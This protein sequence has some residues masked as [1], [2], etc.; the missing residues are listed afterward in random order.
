[1]IPEARIPRETFPNLS[2]EDFYNALIAIQNTRL[3]NAREAKD[4]HKMLKTLRT[5]YVE[6]RRAIIGESNY[7]AYETVRLKHAE[8]L[9]SVRSKRMATS[10]GSEEYEKT[11]NKLGQELGEFF[12][13]RGINEEKF[14]AL[15]QEQPEKLESA[16][17]KTLGKGKPSLPMEHDAGKGISD[18]EFFPPLIGF[19]ECEPY[20]RVHEWHTDRL[21]IMGAAMFC[22]LFDC[23]EHDSEPAMYRQS[24]VFGEIAERTGRVVA[25]I[26]LHPDHFHS[27]MSVRDNAGRSGVSIRRTFKAFAQVQSPFDS[28]RIYW[29]E[30][31][32][33]Q[34]IYNRHGGVAEV[35][36]PNYVLP[37]WYHEEARRLENFD[38]SGPVEDIYDVVYTGSLQDDGETWRY[39][40]LMPGTVDAGRCVM[41]IVGIEFHDYVWGDDCTVSSSLTFQ[42]TTPRISFDVV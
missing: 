39:Q 18:P 16:Y 12:A 30:G 20:D 25:T 28:G 17:K 23:G 8:T 24:W 6:K 26:D 13:D 2:D 37:H 15:Q 3:T 22:D 19:A 9:R 14:I 36:G 34:I 35:G 41:V 32:R 11:R 5:E 40:M 21:G 33:D 31:D 27:S 29:Q 42:F 1:M 7:E 38:R 10:K 4:Y